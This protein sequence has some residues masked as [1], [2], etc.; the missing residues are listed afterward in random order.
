MIKLPRISG[1]VAISCFKKAGYEVVRQKGSHVRLLH[2]T[3]PEK[4]PLT[5]PNHS[6]LGTG[7]LHKL[8]RDA[9]L[10]LK[11]FLDLL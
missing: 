10:S 2:K 8:L 9:H 5:V 4:K 3:D 11:E 1:K 6:E 7:L